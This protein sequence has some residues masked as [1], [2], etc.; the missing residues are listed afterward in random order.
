M[1]PEERKA[2]LEVR[3]VRERL[4]EAAWAKWEVRERRREVSWVR[5][6]AKVK[7]K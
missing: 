5:A 2:Y 1:S 3:E 4:R 7:A 6:K